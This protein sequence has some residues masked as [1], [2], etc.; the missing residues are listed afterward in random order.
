[1]SRWSADGDRVPTSLFEA[2]AHHHNLKA[3]CPGCGHAAVFHGAA[4]WWLF[5]RRQWGDHLSYVPPRLR[6][7]HCG[8]RGVPV[9]V[10][11][12]PP[13]ATQLPLPSDAEWHRAVRRYRS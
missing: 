5:Q 3:R 1:M 12:E 2:A 9:T 4:L 6:C 13:T 10:C 8:R 7:S 11:Q